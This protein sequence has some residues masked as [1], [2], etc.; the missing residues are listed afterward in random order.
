MFFA[1]LFFL[2]AHEDAFLETNSE[3][4]DQYPR[5]ELGLSFKNEKKCLYYMCIIA[6][7][8]LQDFFLKTN[9][10]NSRI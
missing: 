5:L 10:N 4:P 7:V 1:L 6:P 8:I 9:K 3:L 2:F